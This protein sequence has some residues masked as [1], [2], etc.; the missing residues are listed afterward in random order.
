MKKVLALVL[1]AVLLICFLTACSNTKSSKAYTFTV[2]NGNKIKVALN[3]EDNYDLSSEVPFTISCDGKTLS[4][5]SFILADAYQQ[6]VSV[7][8]T[9]E[10]AKLIDS[11]TK[12]GN[13]YIFWSYNDSEYNYAILIK[14]SNTGVV[15]GNPV[16]KE[17]AKECF[18]RMTIT[19]ED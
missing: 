1:S 3:T 4:Q 17:S 9:D 12:D 7:V 18:D 2:D 8:N 14:G 13:E 16:S 6:Y 19:V 5:G 15:L 10:N 11:G